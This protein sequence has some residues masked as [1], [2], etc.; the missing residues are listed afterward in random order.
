[1]RDEIQRLI[2]DAINES[3]SDDDFERLQ[4]A[5]ERDDEVRDE[6]L[7]A[8]RV[9]S[10]LGEISTLDEIS[11]SEFA[12]DESNQSVPANDE[13]N[14]AGSNTPDVVF[15]R[16]EPEIRK[17]IWPSL[18]W[19][20]QLA[21][22]ASV[23]AL[24]GGLAYW[25]GRN[26]QSDRRVQVVE[27]QS[28]Q[29]S[30]AE[31]RIAGHAVL[32]QSVGVQWSENFSAYRA[33]DVI[34]NGPLRFE[35]GSAEIDFFCGAT[36]IIDGP[37]ELDIQSDWAV[38]VIE[39][40]LRANVPPAARGFIVKAN[41]SDIVD[42]GTE[43]A[44][45]IGPDR[46]RLEVIDGE[47]ELRGGR[48]DGDR[49]LTGDRRRLDDSSGDIQSLKNVSTLD[50]LEQRKRDALS[51]RIE[52]WR[53]TVQHQASDDRLVAYYP[54]GS[55]VG[56]NSENDRII[57]N[58]AA[59]GSAFDAKLIG[60]VQ[61][62]DGRFASDSRG[63]DRSRG[64]EFDR[65]G[66]RARLRID[67]T[68]TAFTFSCWVRI[69]SLDHVYNAL[70]MADGYENGEPHWQI[71]DDGRLM[72]SVMVDDSKDV[73]VRSRVDDQEVKDAGLHRIYFTEPI[74]G[75]LQKRPVV[76]YRRC[77]QSRE[78]CG[79]PVRQRS[80]RGTRRNHRPV[81]CE[82]VA[83]RRRRNRQLGTAFSQQSVVC[84]SEFEWNHR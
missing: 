4:D 62:G 20:S 2:F 28:S 36:L 76:A 60:P 6:Y 1:M 19:S 12:D 40:R 37:A 15:A 84:R 52:A 78:A 23:L 16:K 5:I 25:L 11:T 50:E 24:V 83:N 51:A 44:L 39:G 66:A 43:F 57:K 82:R 72:F 48:H 41:D 69:D 74:W 65:A 79:F 67:G 55:A 80:T 49:L 58:L 21:I 61:N 17:R 71:R 30:A 31:K 29:E 53:R 14:S 47:V 81:F 59:S 46:S 26:Q 64:L 8:V 3:I 9:A 7:F 10:L 75:H 13:S 38:R 70:F 34:P 54:V 27:E 68:F 42:L 77:L 45:D 32:R 22:A 56:R 73:R 35:K 63:E 33:G 18:R